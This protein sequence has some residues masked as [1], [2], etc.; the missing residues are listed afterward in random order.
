MLFRS[1]AGIPDLLAEQLVHRVEWA[2][3]M[4]TLKRATE[5]VAIGPAKVISNLVRQNL[6]SGARVRRVAGIDDL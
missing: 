5:F 2:E 3:T 1:D 6:G 4:S